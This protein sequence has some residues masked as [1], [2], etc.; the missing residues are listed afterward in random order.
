MAAPSQVHIAL[1]Y[2]ESHIHVSWQSNAPVSNCSARV[3]YGDTNETLIYSAVPECSTYRITDMCESPAN[4][5][6]RFLAPGTLHDAVLAVD[7]L[8]GTRMVYYRIDGAPKVYAVRVLPKSPYGPQGWT[9]EY[10]YSFASF[11][12]LGLASSYPQAGHT[13]SMLHTIINAT[14]N[15]SG[16][17]EDAPSAA[18]VE[19]PINYVMLVGDVWYASGWG[20][21]YKAFMEQIEP[22]ASVVPW[23]VGPGNHDTLCT[24]NNLSLCTFN[25][26]WQLYLHSGGSGGDCGVPYD[27]HFFMPGVNGT[28]N[29][30]WY[31]YDHGPVHM[32]VL[33]SEEDMRPGSVQHAFLESDLALTRS[34]TPDAWIIVSFHRPI[35]GAS[36]VELAPERTPIRQA[37]EP[38]LVQYGVDIVLSGH[39]HQY[40]RPPCRM[41]N[42]LCNDNGVFY[43]TIGNAGPTNTNAIMPF[44]P[45]TT[46]FAHGPTRFDVLNR[47]HLKG[48]AYEGESGAIIDEFYVTRE[49]LPAPPPTSPPPTPPPPPS[50]SPPP[51]PP[52]LSPSPPSPPPHDGRPARPPLRPPLPSSPQPPVTPPPTPA[53]HWIASA[54]ASSSPMPYGAI[55]GSLCGAVTLVVGMALFLRF[56]PR[57][58][59]DSQV[60]LKHTSG[61]APP[62]GAGSTE[63][64][65]VHE[66]APISI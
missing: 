6:S 34:R 10:P 35:V 38:T 29:N 64:V 3:W 21:K 48:T 50:P 14:L 41:V 33:S 59:L 44:S 63:L 23:M 52:P 47:T 49:A 9:G 17:L 55:V 27:R 30:R 37:L 15:V 11:G 20:T 43:L 51:N 12:D 16:S 56:R 25:P 28:R 4:L 7:V 40:M 61:V 36:W 42:K 66:T 24:G 57:R 5:P 60:M 39:V 53:P 22:V 8:G 1:G 54:Q 62:K 13:M 19:S 32:I 58:G 26:P 2:D 31:S 46:S 65:M 45:W 18:P